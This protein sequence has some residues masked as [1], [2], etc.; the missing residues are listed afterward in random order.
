[1]TDIKT[2]LGKM[3]HSFEDRFLWANA[4]FIEAVKTEKPDHDVEAAYYHMVEAR[5]ALQTLYEDMRLWHASNGLLK[6]ETVLEWR[7]G[8]RT[9]IP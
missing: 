3:Q 7:E 9:R 2:A 5:R 4:A 8:K 1:M 6:V